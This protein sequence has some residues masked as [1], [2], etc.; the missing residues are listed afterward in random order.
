VP[1]TVFSQQKNNLSFSLDY[2]LTSSK[3]GMVKD[4]LA[5]TNAFSSYIYDKYPTNTLS[6]T[7]GVGFEIGYQPFKFQDFTLGMNYLF[8][9][10]KRGPLFKMEDPMDP[11]QINIYKGEYRLT[12]NA[13][14]FLIGSKTYFNS[15]FHF[16]ENSSKLLQR[17]ILASEYKIGFGCSKLSL[18][19]TYK[20][21][22][23]VYL[24][25][26]FFSSDLNGQFNLLVGYKIIEGKIV[27]TIN[28][29]VGYQYYKTKEVRNHSENTFYY[30]FYNTSSTSKPINLDFSGF[31]FGLQLTLRK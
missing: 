10:I 3:M 18:E 12:I 28:L 1:L 20:Y 11:S 4:Y 24:A 27:S 19:E 17:L 23:Q 13:F 30:Y 31:N 6:K 2:S 21:P 9:G 7:Q 14:N 15:L 5:D 26:S 22:E 8:C 29:K 25:Q 16:E